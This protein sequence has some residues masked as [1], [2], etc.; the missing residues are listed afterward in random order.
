MIA[1]L[2]AVTEAHCLS[3]SGSFVPVQAEPAPVRAR[4]HSSMSL[5]QLPEEHDVLVA[6][7]VADLLHAAMV[8]FEQTLGRCNAELLQISQRTVSCGL[9][10]AA[11]EIPQAHSYASRG[12]VER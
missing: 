1:H 8:A 12:G 2:R 3:P 6:D 7:G 5:K 4:R 9:L 10:K 11:N